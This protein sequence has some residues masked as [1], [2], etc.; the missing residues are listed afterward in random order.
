MAYRL[1]DILQPSELRLLRTTFHSCC[2]IAS[3][4]LR[5]HVFL[6]LRTFLLPRRKRSAGGQTWWLRPARNK[7]VDMSCTHFFLKLKIAAVE[8]LY[9]TKRKLLYDYMAHGHAIKP[10]RD[11][12]LQCLSEV[13]RDLFPLKWHVEALPG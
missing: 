10:L 11:I 7:W 1:G 8:I 2:A 5:I 6:Y 9:G 3:E 13:H 12:A 4:L